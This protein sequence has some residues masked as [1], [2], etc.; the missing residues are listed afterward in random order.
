MSHYA[1]QRQAVLKLAECGL[2]LPVDDPSIS[3][4]AG[5][6]A[7]LG[8]GKFGNVRAATL[9]GTPVCAKQLHEPAAAAAAAASSLTASAFFPAAGGGASKPSSTGAAVESAFRTFGPDEEVALLAELAAT[10]RL[11]HPR[12]VLFLGVAYDP[13]TYAPVSLLTERLETSVHDLLARRGA[14]LEPAEV[15]SVAADVAG[16]LAFLH[17][18][19]P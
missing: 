15:F 8:R 2:A 9:C 7:V 17:G 11:Q 3:V 10:T 12:L 5:E 16:A 4:A 18:R 1:M 13:R 6:Q 19:S 14:F